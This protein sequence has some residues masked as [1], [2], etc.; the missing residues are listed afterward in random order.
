MKYRVINY[1]DVVGNRKDGY[2][3]NNLCEYAVVEFKEYPSKRDV[4]EKMKEIGFFKKSVR[5]ASFVDIGLG[6]AEFIEYED[7]FG[8]PVFRLERTGDDKKVLVH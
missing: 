2:E 3:V 5:L 6:D 8:R 7:R 1:F 4:M